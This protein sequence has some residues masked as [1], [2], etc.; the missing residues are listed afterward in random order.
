MKC[1]DN[2]CFIG[3]LAYFNLTYGCWNVYGGRCSETRGKWHSAV[4]LFVFIYSQTFHIARMFHIKIVIHR[5]LRFKLD[6]RLL[7]KI[8]T[9]SLYLI[10]I[11]ICFPIASSI[12]RPIC[13]TVLVSF[14]VV[15]FLC[16]IINE[17]VSIKYLNGHEKRKQNNLKTRYNF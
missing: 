2:V 8:Y 4:Y 17:R 3:W 12:V 1:R 13:H 11:F 14:I 10:N 7:T 16:W 9:G 15:T 6:S 5:Y